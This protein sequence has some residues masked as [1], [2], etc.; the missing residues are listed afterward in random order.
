MDNKVD[1]QVKGEKT[2]ITGLLM[3]RFGMTKGMAEIIY[4]RNK[5]SDFFDE[6]WFNVESTYSDSAGSKAVKLT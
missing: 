2:R 1:M 3:S 5:D 6:P 4:E